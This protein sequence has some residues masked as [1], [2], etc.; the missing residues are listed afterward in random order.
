MQFDAF[1][2]EFDAKWIFLNPRRQINVKSSQWALNCVELISTQFFILECVIVC[3]CVCACTCVC[4][5]VRSVCVWCVCGV[6]VWVCVCV[7][8]CVLFIIICNKIEKQCV[9]CAL[10]THTRTNTHLLTFAHTRAL[11][12]IHTPTHVSHPK[13]MNMRRS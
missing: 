5:C 4:V 1:C 12:R 6:C 11:T 7:C 9:V 13:G 3:V 8:V 2:V 10:H